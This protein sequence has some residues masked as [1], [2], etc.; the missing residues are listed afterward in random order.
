VSQDTVHVEGLSIDEAVAR[1][2][3]ADPSFD[4]EGARRT[5]Y[6]V[7]EDGTVTRAAVDD[8]LA[9]A[10]KVVATPETRIE[11]AGIALDEARDTAA[12]VADIDLVAARL[13]AFATRLTALEERADGLGD[14]LESITDMADDTALFE[15]ATRLQA[16][17][18]TA[19]E[20]QAAADELTM[21]IEAFERWVTAPSQRAD[22]LVADCD[23]LDEAIAALERSVAGLDRAAERAPE[24]TGRA[25][26]DAALR[27]RLLAALVADC[28]AE[29]AALTT[30]A[31]RSATDGDPDAD[32]VAR[33]DD[34][35]AVLSDELASLQDDI[36][37]V[38]RAA[39][40]EQY[41]DTVAG[42][43]AEI[44]ALEHPIDWATARS[45]FEKRRAAI[46]DS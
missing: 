33:L 30:L 15:L 41:G 38:A 26:A 39:W 25:W 2:V 3:D 40:H 12:P 9:H 18:V 10:A 32:W 29:H 19:N 7:T 1:V 17:T 45:A 36:N 31:G 5:L 24:R 43:D 42:L 28:R 21:D 14:E 37:A 16:L 4:P 34:R 27:C 46:A 8:A 22:D 11:L 23:A 44:D 13:D 6:H 20:V 35:L